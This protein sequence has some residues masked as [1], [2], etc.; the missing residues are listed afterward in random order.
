MATT[1]T[2]TRPEARVLE[3]ALEDAGSASLLQSLATTL[4]SQHGVRTH[5]FVARPVD[6]PDASP[7]ETSPT[8]PVQTLGMIRGHEAPEGGWPQEVQRALAALDARLTDRGWHS[9]GVGDDW[10]A[11]RYAR[12]TSGWTT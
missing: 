7:V 8:F 2:G 10:W 6:D 4:T 3:V 12:D 5:R 1:T 11:R 9:V